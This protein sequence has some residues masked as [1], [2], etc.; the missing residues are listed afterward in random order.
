MPNS[1]RSRLLKTFGVVVLVLLALWFFVPPGSRETAE[2]VLKG[3]SFGMNGQLYIE[4]EQANERGFN[5]LIKIML[6]SYHT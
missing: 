3:E 2:Q 4:K 6:K 5:V 1:G